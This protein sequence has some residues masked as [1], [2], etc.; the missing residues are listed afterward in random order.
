[1]RGDKCSHIFSSA[2]AR[3][4]FFVLIVNRVLLKVF[5]SVQDLAIEDK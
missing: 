1:M 4:D 5:H 2:K 3:H